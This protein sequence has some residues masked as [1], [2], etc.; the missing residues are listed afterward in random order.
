MDVNTQELLDKALSMEAAD[1][2]FIAERLIASLDTEFDTE[3]ELA[4]QQEVLKRVSELDKGKVQTIS[5]EQ[6]K[7]QISK[8]LSVKH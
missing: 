4:W 1:R 2:A 6:V 7:N 3:V 5:W 8:E